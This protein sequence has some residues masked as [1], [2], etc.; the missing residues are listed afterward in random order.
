MTRPADFGFDEEAQIL[1]D[2]ARRLLHEQCANEA[3]HRLVAA[4]S[5]PA[6]ARESVWD[7]ALWRRIVELGVGTHAGRCVEVLA[8]NDLVVDVL[9][10]GGG[11]VRR[12][13]EPLG[14]RAGE[15]EI[16][17]TLH[18]VDYVR[19]EVVY[20]SAINED[21]GQHAVVGGHEPVGQVKVLRVVD[22]DAAHLRRIGNDHVCDVK[23]LASGAQL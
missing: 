9:H 15:H 11:L 10:G 22:G 5:A 2:T 8:A 20:Q 12:R 19:F 16:G 23:P 6:R 21:L 18:R 7:R 14:I 1:R 3:L 13:R 17:A 4:S